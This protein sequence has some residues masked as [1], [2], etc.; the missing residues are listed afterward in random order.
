MVSGPWVRVSLRDAFHLK[1]YADA[2]FNVVA[3]TS[4]TPEI[5]QEVADLRGIPRVYETI[6]DLLDDKAVEILDIAVPPDKQL[7]IVRTAVRRGKYL[8]GILAQ[9][10]L[11]V[12]YEQAA[13]IVRLCEER[14]TPA[15][16]EPEY[17]L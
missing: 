16:R 13:E 1:A 14:Q 17:A 3:I 10:P 9:K 15:G 6:E 2:G 7:E 11:A 12:N 4:R 5:A 8:K